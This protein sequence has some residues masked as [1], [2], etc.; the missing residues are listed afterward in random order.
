MCCPAID[1]AS[2]SVKGRARTCSVRVS[3]KLGACSWEASRASTCLRR[4]GSAAQASCRKAARWLASRSSAD[5]NSCSTCRK[6]SGVIQASSGERAVQPGFGQGPLPL[7]RGRRDPQHFGGLF[8]GEPAEEPQL[9]HLAL[10]RVEG[11]QPAQGLVERHQIRAFLLRD[12]NRLLQGQLNGSSASFGGTVSQRVVDQ[13]LAHQIGRDAKEVG[14]ALA[15]H[16]GL[17]Y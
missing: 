8:D 16:L 10:L 9:H 15:A 17:V 2:P 12:T 4:G 1:W 3:K 13:D 6:R 14:P 7:D 5:S 11:R